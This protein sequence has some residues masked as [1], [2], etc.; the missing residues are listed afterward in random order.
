MVKATNSSRAD[1]N[2]I[3]ALYPSRDVVVTPGFLRLEQSL[4]AGAINSIQFSVLDN[5]SSNG[6][7]QNSTEVR[8][9]LPDSFHITKIFFGI[10]KAG[11]SVTA[12]QAEIAQAI[13]RTYP[14]PLVFTGAGEA[15]ALQ[16]FYNGS[17]GIKVNQTTYI[18]RDELR[19][20]YRVGT[21]QQGVG[22]AV[23][24]QRDEF[25]APDFGF[26]E[27]TPTIRLSGADSNFITC[28]FPQSISMIGTLSQNFAVC[29]CRGFYVQ[30]GAQFNPAR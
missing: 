27:L 2:S 29:F 28:T 13:I 21:S 10:F 16:N 30:N 17:Y 22:P 6:V 1:F 9:R 18:D 12:T 23:I 4:Q 3:R 20:F 19:K 15:A 5:Q 8:L 24:I 14:N 25:D 26:Y 7:A 11:A